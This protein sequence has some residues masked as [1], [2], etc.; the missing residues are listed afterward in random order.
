MADLLSRGFGIHLMTALV[1]EHEIKFYADNY[2]TRKQHLYQLLERGFERN[3]ISKE[4]L[5]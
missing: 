2:N 5:L 1:G 4:P 3:E